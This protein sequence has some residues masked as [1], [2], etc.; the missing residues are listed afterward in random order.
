MTDTK[1]FKILVVKDRNFGIREGVKIFHGNSK[2]VDSAM[3]YEEW[4]DNCGEHEDAMETGDYFEYL[5][6]IGLTHLWDVRYV[7][8]D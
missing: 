3:S 5:E 2:Q 1:D 6:N 4:Y 7:Y 8:I